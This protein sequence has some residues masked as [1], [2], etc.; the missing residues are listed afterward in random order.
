LEINSCLSKSLQRI[1]KSGRIA[2]HSVPHDGQT[3]E[4]MVKAADRVHKCAVGGGVRIDVEIT[5][6]V[7]EN[8]VDLFRQ[9][10]TLP[11]RLFWVSPALFFLCS[12]FPLDLSHYR[13]KLRALILLLCIQSPKAN[14]LLL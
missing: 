2:D 6:S 7:Q 9:D 4:F 11:L 3:D 8:I 1:D 14:R 13:P 5:L 10:T 12:L